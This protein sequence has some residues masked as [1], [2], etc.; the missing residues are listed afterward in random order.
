MKN[1][2][3]LIQTGH[4]IPWVMEAWEKLLEKA[5]IDLSEKHRRILESFQGIQ[6]C[7]QR[8]E[9]EKGFQMQFQ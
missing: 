9:T 8:D 5:G 3:Y 4:M 6:L 2:Y 7:E 1:D